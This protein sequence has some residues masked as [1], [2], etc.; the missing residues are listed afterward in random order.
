MLWNLEGK[1][2]ARENQ[3]RSGVSFALGKLEGRIG[4]SGTGKRGAGG[5]SG[6]D[7]SGGSS[8]VTWRETRDSSAETDACACARG[9]HANSIVSNIFPC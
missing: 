4:G 7:L 6:Q 9:A 8:Q 1:I 5:G 2:G 3:A